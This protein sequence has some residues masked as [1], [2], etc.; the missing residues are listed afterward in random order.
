MAASQPGE[1]VGKSGTVYKAC[2]VA[3]FPVPGPLDVVDG[4]GAGCLDDDLAAAAR[5]ALA[6]PRER[7]RDYAL[8]FSWRRCAEQFLANL[9]PIGRAAPRQ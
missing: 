4:S 7:C 6:I 3:A 9:Q 8:G 2:P 1:I 5:A